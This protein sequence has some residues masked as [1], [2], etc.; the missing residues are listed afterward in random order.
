MNGPRDG[1]VG[2]NV[3]I[4][5]NRVSMC[6]RGI[7]VVMDGKINDT[8]HRHRHGGGWTEMK[9]HGLVVRSSRPINRV[10]MCRCGIAVVVDGKVNDTVHSSRTR[11]LSQP[12]I[13]QTR[14]GL[15][16]PLP[17]PLLSRQKL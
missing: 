6:C 14:K 13:G 11:G 1:R 16:S 5:I 10:S 15:S 3:G 12:K 7:A 2:L 8:V 17:L 9:G 4:P